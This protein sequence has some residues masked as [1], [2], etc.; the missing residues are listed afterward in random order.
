MKY[1]LILNKTKTAIRNEFNNGLKVIA[2]T[3]L[4]IA[5]AT[6]DKGAYAMLLDYVKSQSEKQGEDWSKVKSQR[7]KTV[8]AGRAIAYAFYDKI[9][10]MEEA[11]LITF[12]KQEK[13]TNWSLILKQYKSDG[14]RKDPKAEPN[15]NGPKVQTP[16]VNDTAAVTE[17]QVQA[18][19]D[20]FKAM[21][22]NVFWATIRNLKDEEQKQAKAA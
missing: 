5:L 21:D 10:T 3:A 18:L 14:S 8:Q 22:P 19:V 13:L 16:I 7:T 4:S 17:S 20:L 12:L 15:P 1:D 6:D 2:N 11:D 9:R